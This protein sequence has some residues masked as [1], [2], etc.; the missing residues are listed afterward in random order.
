M[1]YL[2]TETVGLHG[3]IVLIQW[4]EDDG[5]INLHCP[6]TCPVDDTLA[7]IEKFANHETGIC[8]FNLAFDWFHLYKLWTIFRLL[9]EELE[10][11]G[12]FPEDHIDMLVDIEERARDYPKA[13]K[14]VTAIDI[15]LH[16]RKGPYQST[17][18]RKNVVI[19]KVPAQLAWLLA[20][21]LERRI[22]LKD[23]YF[24]RRKNKNEP[25]WQ[26]QDRKDSFGDIDPDWKNVVVRFKPSSALKALAVDALPNINQD[27]VLRY[28]D[29]SPKMWPVEF[30]YVPFAKGAMK[31]KFRN[32]TKEK[33]RTLKYRNTWPDY[34]QGHITHW[35]YNTLARKYAEDDIY[36]TR[37]LYKYF[38]SPEPGDDDSVL[39]CMVGMSRWRGYR[40][41]VEGIKELKQR[42]LNR[43]YISVNNHGNSN[44]QKLLPTAPNDVKRYLMDACD[45]TEKLALMADMRGRNDKSPQPNTKKVTLETIAKDWATV[46][47]PECDGLDSSDY[48]GGSAAGLIPNH[49]PGSQYSQENPC[50]KCNGKKTIRHEASIRAQQILDCRKAGKEIE[51][52]DKLLAA[53]RLHASFKVIGTLSSR[54]SG[55]DGLNAQSIKKTKE[56]KSV[57][58]LAQEGYVLC[59]GDFSSFEVGIAES[60][61]NDSDLRRDLLTCEKCQSQMSFNSSIYD[62]ECSNQNCRSNKGMK[63]HGIFGTYLFPG[64]TYEQIKATDGTEDDKYT[65]AKQAVF[66]KMYG[67]EAHTMN[68]RL[69][70]PLDQADEANRLFDR[71]YKGVFRAQ[72]VVKNQ[73]QSMRQ[74][75]GRGTKVE[76]HDPAEKIE[77]MFGF[78]RY[79]TLENRICKS[80]YDLAG[81]LP[82]AFRDIRL[83]V[84]R[85]D[86]QQFMGGAVSSAMYSAAFSIQSFNKRAA[87]NHRIQGSGAQITKHVQRRIWDIQPSGIHDWL[88]QPMNVHDSIMTP[89]KPHKVNEVKLMVRDTVETYRPKIPL[90]GMPWATYLSDWADKGGPVCSL[91]DSGDILQGYKNRHKLAPLKLSRN[92]IHQVLSKQRDRYKGMRWRLLT[93]DEAKS[94]TKQGL[95]K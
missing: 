53:G 20:E 35:G 8:G 46:E 9:K 71:K 62:Y 42:A 81:R 93:E 85:T 12:V 44:E 65:K 91:S 77:T 56:V 5:P 66:L 13:L 69:G 34:I 68:E 31:V 2:D 17:M 84:I 60:E 64:M 18:D 72:E 30:G 1:I 79:F 37:A 86:R 32:K 3:L 51:L 76:W 19:R 47:C 39:A 78:A 23:I 24:A 11:G 14:P 54:M 75:G 89:V 41:D 59:G 29:I 4:A 67:G 33:K 36:Y 52:Y 58:L 48:L 22:P 49:C 70:V 92:R 61:Y 88:V 26:V 50:P 40:I 45:A 6:W 55:A 87:I 16:A 95:M 80:L 82:K 10:D 15:F 90:I 7:L 57:F 21:E 28:G 94:L 73:F 83:R 43:K 27:Q 38:N 74:P 25:K 63:F